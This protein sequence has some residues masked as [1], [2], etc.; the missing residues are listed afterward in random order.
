MKIGKLLVKY[1]AC[2]LFFSLLLGF[3]QFAF[4]MSIP[5]LVTG[6]ATLLIQWGLIYGTLKEVDGNYSNKTAIAVGVG[7]AVPNIISVYL[8]LAGL[9]YP[10][11]NSSVAAIM[12][13]IVSI[14]VVLGIF[15]LSRQ[16]LI[17]IAAND[18]YNS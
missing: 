5:I 9:R 3:N 7:I 6:F 14:V 15:A 13:G 2:I 12:V 4:Q 10:V 16:M 18:E 1:Y 17:S 8:F 11:L